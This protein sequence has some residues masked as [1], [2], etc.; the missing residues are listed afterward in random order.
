MKL[1][2]M[3]NRWHMYILGLSTGLIGIGLQNYNPLEPRAC[4]HACTIAVGIVP[5]L[6]LILF[7]IIRSL[8]KELH[9][10]NKGE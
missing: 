8:I 7:Q 10:T 5:L 2:D 9:K 3:M 6:L 1:I 4:T